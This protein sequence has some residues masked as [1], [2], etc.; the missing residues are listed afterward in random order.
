MIE[1]HLAGNGGLLSGGGHGA[2][3]LTEHGRPSLWYR[4]KD[5]TMAV[6]GQGGIGVRPKDLT[7]LDFSTDRICRHKDFFISTLRMAGPTAIGVVNEP[8]IA[9]TSTHEEYP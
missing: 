4:Q 3:S 5:C 2:L 8:M 9:Q 7:P 6:Q 1:E